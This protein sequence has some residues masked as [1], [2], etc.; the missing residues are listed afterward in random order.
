[1]H[2]F[3]LIRPITNFLKNSMAIIRLSINALARNDHSLMRP[4]MQRKTRVQQ[5]KSRRSNVN[6]TKE[7]HLISGLQSKKTCRMRHK[8]A[9][10]GMFE[11]KLLTSSSE[12]PFNSET[13]SPE[14]GSQ[15]LS[16]PETPALDSSSITP[17]TPVSQFPITPTTSGIS[18]DGF[19][20]IDA[21]NMHQ[22]FPGSERKID[23]TT[24]FVGGLEIS[25][26]E[27]WD[28]E[29]VR[30]LFF[31]FGGLE[32]VKFFRP[33]MYLFQAEFSISSST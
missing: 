2:F 29:R 27:A 11:R 31:R 8:V 1:M 10:L 17:V 20:P 7:F 4:A 19:E 23:P 32:S 25:G 26:P 30:K 15:E 6:G 22:N 24:L 12:N 3:L 18:C 14:A 13:S 28:E 21:G 16:I 33:S 5:V 9:S